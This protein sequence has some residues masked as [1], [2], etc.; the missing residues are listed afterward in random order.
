M[1]LRPIDF[2]IL[3]E[4]K[5]GRNVAANIHMTLDTSRQYVNERMGFLHDYDLVR[6]VGPNQSVGLYEITL[7]GELVVEHWSKYKNP[8]VDFDEFIDKELDA[9]ELEDEG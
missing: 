6:R 3:S 8:T 4:L 1:K 5:K 2:S 9:S 7:K